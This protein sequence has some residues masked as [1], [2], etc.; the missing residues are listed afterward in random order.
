MASS[1][2]DTWKFD[3]TVKIT[4]SQKSNGEQILCKKIIRSI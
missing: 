1:K 2:R 4:G 3:W